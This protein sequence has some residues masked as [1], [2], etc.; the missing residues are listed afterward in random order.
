MRDRGTPTGRRR[1]GRA[2]GRVERRRAKIGASVEEY[3]LTIVG[4][5]GKY[6]DAIG[7]FVIRLDGVNAIA[8]GDLIL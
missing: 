7:D 3:L 4:A 5:F 2:A 6:L 8:T 1:D